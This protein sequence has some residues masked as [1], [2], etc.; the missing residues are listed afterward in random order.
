MV[1]GLAFRQEIHKEVTV[2]GQTRDDSGLDQ[3]G[4]LMG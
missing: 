4:S 2:S 1:G 3:S